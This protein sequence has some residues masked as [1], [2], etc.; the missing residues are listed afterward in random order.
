MTTDRCDRGDEVREMYVE[1]SGDL[2]AG[3]FSGAWLDK[4][5]F[6]D[7]EYAVPGI[8]SEG[9]GL[10]V[11]PPK[12]GKSWLVFGL[13]LACAIGGLALGRIRVDKRPVLYIALE[14]GP[15]RLQ[16]RSRRIMG[17]EPLPADIHFITKAKPAE[18]IPTISEFLRQHSGAKP[19]IILDT[20][21][22]ARPPRP[23]GADLYAWDYAIGAGL[24]DVID[25][26]PGAA[27]L[28][29]H[30]TR[31]AESS[32]FVD[33]VSGSHGIAGAADF[34]LVLA[35]KR[36]S[37]EA[38]LS[39][40][41]RDVAEAEYALA[42]DD[43]VWR[44]DGTNLTEAASNAESRRDQ[45]HLGDRARE[46]VAFVSNRDGTRAA[47]LSA[48]GIDQEQAR[49][50]LNRLSEG[51]RIQKVGRGLYKKGG[52]TSVSSVTN[53]DQEPENVTL[54]TNVTPLFGGGTE[55]ALCGCGA[56]LV[57]PESIESGR[58]ME[59]SVSG[60]SGR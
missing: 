58:C 5:N 42:V 55:V 57:H 53:S 47:D 35:R 20:L 14:D 27:L 37:D 46:V 32:D 60:G 3:M 13:A 7:L 23:P 36:H 21:G 28:V 52:V 19:L 1:D 50:Y 45:A 39:V 25:T 24:K 40:T 41:G 11:A 44:L 9:L 26:A 8:V 22:K 54:V 30:H 17:G 56:S 18:V 10:L 4:Q 31:K 51:G 29:V 38:L 6:P 16:S 48:I 33:S 49:V 34:L 12:V 2:L 43:G 15:R 59:C